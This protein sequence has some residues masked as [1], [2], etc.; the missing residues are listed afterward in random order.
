V[1]L[2]DFREQYSS[3]GNRIVIVFVSLFRISTI[4]ARDV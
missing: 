2:T 4:P 3:R 1:P